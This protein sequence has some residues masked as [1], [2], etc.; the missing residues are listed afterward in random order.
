[1]DYQPRH[2]APTQVPDTPSSATHEQP[3]TPGRFE[4]LL[5]RY[6]E[7]L[8]AYITLND[9]PSPQD[10]ELEPQLRLQ[11]RGRFHTLRELWEE[12]V[13]ASW[14]ATLEATSV[15]PEVWTWDERGIS[16]TLAIVYDLVQVN[17]WIYAFYK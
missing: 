17:D 4:D 1:M 8:L 10:P 11:R 3:A 6:G 16:E 9:V 7:E 2:R 15:P 14:G 12:D 13:A 5:E